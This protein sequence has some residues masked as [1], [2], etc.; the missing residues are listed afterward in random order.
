M[1]QVEAG[2]SA[3]QPR[4][5]R[6]GGRRQER[7]RPDREPVGPLGRQEVER[8]PAEPVSEIP[9]GGRSQPPSAMNPGFLKPG[10]L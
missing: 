10:L 7:Q 8:P 2:Q 5:G 4:V 9:E 3:A 6:Q 1:R